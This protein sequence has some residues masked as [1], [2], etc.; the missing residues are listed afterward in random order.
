MDLTLTGWLMEV[1]ETDTAGWPREWCRPTVYSPA[2][3]AAAAIAS[4]SRLAAMAA[5]EAVDRALEVSRAGA[6]CSSDEPS[7]LCSPPRTKPRHARHPRQADPHVRAKEQRRAAALSSG[8]AG[9]CAPLRADPA[10]G[11]LTT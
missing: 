8:P 11:M 9:S 5:R 10:G 4:Y 2:T 3:E 6:S 7:T 1:A